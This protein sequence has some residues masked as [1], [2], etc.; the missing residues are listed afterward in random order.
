MLQGKFH[1][2]CQLTRGCACLVN[3]SS[4]D[5]R[6]SNALH[7]LC[8][9]AALYN[10]K[11]AAG[12]GHWE[13]QSLWQ[14][15]KENDSRAADSFNAGMQAHER[16]CNRHKTNCALV[17]VISLPHFAILNTISWAVLHFPS[18]AD[19]FQCSTVVGQL[20]LA[21]PIPH[22]PLSHPNSIVSAA[23]LCVDTN[24]WTDC[25]HVPWL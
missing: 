24:A 14:E 23:S 19:P 17:R 8:H 16:R 21:C 4:V 2:C 11:S 1:G 7:F 12:H 6:I 10:N 25:A 13:V 9:T 3:D 15:I 5:A 22:P 20:S 18:S